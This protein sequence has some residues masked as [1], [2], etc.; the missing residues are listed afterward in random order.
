MANRFEII[1][2]ENLRIGV[3]DIKTTILKD[4]IT[5]VLYLLTSRSYDSEVGGLTPLLD[6]NGK[7]I[8]ERENNL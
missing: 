2:S 1:S 7:P 3:N 6:E 5:G 4:K 8:I